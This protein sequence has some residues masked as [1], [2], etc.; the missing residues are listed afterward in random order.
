MTA[1][2][3]FLWSGLAPEVAGPIVALPVQA[4][5]YVHKG[6]LLMQIDPTDYQINVTLAE[7]MVRQDQAMLANLRRKAA[8][9]GVRAWRSQWKTSRPPRPPPWW[10]Q[11][12]AGEAELAQAQVNLART[13]IRAPANGWVTQPGGAAGGLC[14]CGRSPAGTGR[15]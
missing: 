7:A 9:R 15:C 10:L 2:C 1:Q 14:Q 12:A 3:G 8:R 13:Q 4:N 5:Q 6:E 11:Q